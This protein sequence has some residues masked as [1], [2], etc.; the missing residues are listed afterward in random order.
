MS[1]EMTRRDVLPEVAKNKLNA[2]WKQHQK[3]IMAVTAG[4]DVERIARVTYSVLH[5]NPK[6]IECTPFSLLNGIVLGHQL[7][8]MFGTSEVSL[9]PYGTE[10][11]LIIGYQGKAKLA[12]QS[13]IVTS[14]EAEV[15][16]VADSWEYWRDQD[17]LHMLHKPNWAAREDITEDTIIG[18]YCQMGIK[19]GTIQ[20]R[21]VSIGEILKA[22]ASSRGYNYQ[23]SKGRTDNP[24]MTHFSEMALKTAVH[25]A[26]KLIP[27]TPG[28]AKANALEDADQGAGDTVLAEGLNPSDFTDSEVIEP[29]FQASNEAQSNVVTAKVPDASVRAATASDLKKAL[30]TNEQVFWRVMGAHGYESIGSIR[31]EA[32][33]RVVLRDF[34]NEVAV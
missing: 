8:L 27:Q 34:N 29:V 25:R 19:G 1:N 10:A 31:S 20:T 11:T 12:L 17:G 33:A 28:L 5:R 2:F 4:S 32:I 15:V 26:S 3:Q 24:W 16:H 7:G 22:R 30:A 9:V 18:A 6:L 23:K 14:I 13:G 21:F